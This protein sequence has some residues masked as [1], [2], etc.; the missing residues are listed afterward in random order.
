[1]HSLGGLFGTEWVLQDAVRHLIDGCLINHMKAV[2]NEKQKVTLMANGSFVCLF[3]TCSTLK[4][5]LENIKMQY[6]WNPLNKKG[7]SD[8]IIL[9]CYC[10][11]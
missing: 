10:Q 11:G 7:V 6:F 1:M 2:T 9:L 3:F 4:R 8:K 5:R